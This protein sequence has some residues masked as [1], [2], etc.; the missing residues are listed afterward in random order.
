[1]ALEDSHEG[2]LYGLGRLGI[3]RADILHRRADRA[4]PKCL[5]HE[6]QVD[7]AC[8]K[9]RSEGMLQDVRMLPTKP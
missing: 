1:M 3:R 7:I 6:R 8:D 2:R 5:L 4:V 9:M